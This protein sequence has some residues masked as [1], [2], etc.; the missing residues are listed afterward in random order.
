MPEVTTNNH[1]FLRRMISV[2]QHIPI[3]FLVSKRIVKSPGLSTVRQYSV[4]AKP[5]PHATLERNCT[6]KLLPSRQNTEKVETLSVGLSLMSPLALIIVNIE[7]KI[8][9]T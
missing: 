2:V 5:L 4:T 9:R 8:N 3:L 7:R 1:F 6:L